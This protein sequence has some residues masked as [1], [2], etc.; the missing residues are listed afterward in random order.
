[1]CAHD[2]IEFILIHERCKGARKG[3]SNSAILG[4][5]CND[6]TGKALDLDSHCK[7]VFYPRRH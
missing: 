7:I 6:S 3:K 5:F 1:M 2:I 4:R